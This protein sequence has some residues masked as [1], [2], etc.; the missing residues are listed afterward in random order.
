MR[1]IYT[2]IALLAL[3]MA[4]VFARTEASKEA[5]KEAVKE[6]IETHYKVYGFI[7]AYMALDTRE[8]KAGTGDLYYW[9]PLDRSLNAAGE[10]MNAH[11]NG[12]FSAITSRI[13]LDV[14][15]YEVGKAKIGA[16]IEA[17]FYSGVSGVTGTATL[18]LRQAFTTVSWADKGA[19]KYTFK[20][21]QA[22]HPMAADLPDIFDL[23][24]GVPFGPF[25]RSPLAQ[26]DM[27]WGDHIGLT[28]AA[29]WQ[30]QYTSNG[31]EGASANYMKYSC[32]PEAYAGINVTAGSFLLRYG[33][34]SLL[35]KPR[36]KGD[37]MTT[38]V[39]D[40]KAYTAKVSDKL[41]AYS[42]FLY[43][44]YKKGIFAAKAKTIFA[45]SG[46]HM[47][48]LGGYGISE[49]FNN[50]DED[51]HYLYTPTLTSSSWV[52]FSV[53][54]KYQGVLFGGYTKNLGTLNN[55]YTDY[56]ENEGA[57]DVAFYTKTTSCYFGKNASANIQQIWRVEPAFLVNLGKFQV[58]LELQVTSAQYAD[59]FKFATGKADEKGQPAM[60]TY[61]TTK[62][63]CDASTSHWI[64]NHR[65]LC[66]VKYS[67]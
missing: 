20:L 7:R 3:S 17:D 53:G 52:C 41:F 38:G 26:I 59:Y 15:G 67:F 24:S 28:I 35:I 22:W 18:R 9:A 48:I 47:N 45:Q 19:G 44:Q 64:T 39:N 29:I 42:P 54:K 43:L 51:G 66:M 31:P 30:M 27:K 32:V 16:K 49:K 8:S 50:L 13:G 60:E 21:G 4:P 6:H 34:S 40:G 12:K 63:L 25:N 46:E 36:Y 10:D 14:S 65:V 55:L 5:K 62:G 23:E 56:T 58:G 11:I 57:D 33:L 1:K 37:V 2:T 61:V